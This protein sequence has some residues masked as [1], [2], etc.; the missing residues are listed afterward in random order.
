[1]YQL[2]KSYRR[3]ES[4]AVSASLSAYN[5]MSRGEDKTISATRLLTGRAA[6]SSTS[7]FRHFPNRKG[8]AVSRCVNL[9]PE[10]VSVGLGLQSKLPKI[11]KWKILLK[12]LK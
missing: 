9:L 12:G 4:V 3:I 10:T 8:R 7:N 6:Y 11:A 1:M 2:M 5:I